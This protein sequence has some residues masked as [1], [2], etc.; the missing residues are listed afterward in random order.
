M[1]HILSTIVFGSL[2][3]S[4]GPYS[5]APTPA[6]A[7][8]TDSAPQAAAASDKPPSDLPVTPCPCLASCLCASSFSV[9]IGNKWF[10]LLKESQLIV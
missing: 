9:F 3:L 6:L 2:P 8:Q 4:T 10:N 5:A 1:K 7:Q